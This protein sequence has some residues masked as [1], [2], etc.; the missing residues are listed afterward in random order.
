MQQIKKFIFI[1]ILHMYIILYTVKSMQ[2]INRLNY[3][4]ILYKVL[5][6]K[7]YAADNLLPAWEDVL[8]TWRY[9]SALSGRLDWFSGS[10]LFEPVPC[11]VVHAF[12]RCHWTCLWNPPS[13]PS[14]LD[15]CP[16]A[17]LTSASVLGEFSTLHGDCHAQWRTRS[18][19]HSRSCVALAAARKASPRQLANRGGPSQWLMSG[20]TLGTQLVGPYPG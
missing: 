13:I 17:S 14:L 19:Q 7:A 16:A 3:I 5:Y 9:V 6:S 2:Q 15:H 4:L 8:T 10:N 12:T 11:K 20:A 1:E 18:Q